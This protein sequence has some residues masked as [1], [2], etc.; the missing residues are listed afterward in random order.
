M[1]QSSRPT[2][3]NHKILREDSSGN[4]QGA[5]SGGEAFSNEAPPFGVLIKH[6]APPAGAH[7][8]HRTVSIMWSGI[9]K[10]KAC[11]WDRGR[12]GGGGEILLLGSG[13]GSE[14]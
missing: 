11:V 6:C 10:G 14:K 3:Q 4:L 5:A 7:L 8:G 9:T 1:A 2:C 13:E 12:E